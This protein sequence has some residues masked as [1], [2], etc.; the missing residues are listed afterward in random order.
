MVITSLLNRARKEAA[1]SH[2]YQ[3][4]G[5]CIY[6]GGSVLSTGHNKIRY[7]QRGVSFTRFPES[8]HAERDACS[9][10]YKE[11]LYGATICVV[12]INKKGSYRLARPCK[13]C[14][15]LLTALG[16]R[17]IIYSTNTKPY[18]NVEVI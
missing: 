6:K 1:K 2:Y 17:K 7:K 5:A 14:M 12:R 3:R 15:K 4:I 18:Y 8:L 9:K 16:I 10:V 13:D 11:R